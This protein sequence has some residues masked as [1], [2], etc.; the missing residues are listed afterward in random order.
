M[1]IVAF[2]LIAIL[3]MVKS[4][5]NE[6]VEPT[7][8]VAQF[9]DPEP[10]PQVS[11]PVEPLVY[12][13]VVTEVTPPVESVQTQEP[14]RVPEPESEPEPEP[15]PEPTIELAAVSATPT[16]TPPPEPG[17]TLRFASESDFLA[18]IAQSQVQVHA[19]NQH[20]QLSVTPS[21]AVKPGRV[22]GQ[23]YEIDV[24][25]VP[26][27]LVHA[28]GQLADSELLT[29][30]VALPEQIQAQIA[31]LVR[32]QQHGQLLIHRNLKVAHVASR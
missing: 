29:W 32:T 24:R 7:V 4:V 10:Q 30:A 20:T 25:T 17:L 1:A 13:P 15:E 23:V 28:A 5:P 18:L 19:Y 27:I 2:C 31:S 22:T 14:A 8:T 3:A 12:E 6:E 26:P 21:F 11:A 9:P 16:S